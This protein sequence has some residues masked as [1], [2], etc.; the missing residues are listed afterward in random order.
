M[1]M[2]VVRPIRMPT[3][4]K[5]FFS[6]VAQ[7]FKRRRWELIED[8]H[9]YSPTLHCDFYIPAPFDLDFASVPRPFWIIL[10]P[11]GLLLIGS[12]FH[13]FGYL[14]GGLLVKKPAD[15][16]YKFKQYSRIGLDNIFETIITEVNDMKGMA[17]IA[18][19]A[20]IVGGWMAW[21]R[22]RKANRSVFHDYPLCEVCK[23]FDGLSV[24]R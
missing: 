1:E 14:Y 24:I 5:P 15:Q 11:V 16:T 13:D 7:A 19:Y 6:R 3:K 10:D 8:F 18:K 17:K 22:C 23:C 2:P 9:Y 12:M 4:G 20:L 21:A